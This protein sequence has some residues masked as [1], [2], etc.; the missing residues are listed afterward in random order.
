[1]ASLEHYFLDLYSLEQY[2]RRFFHIIINK[3]LTILFMKLKKS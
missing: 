2:S 1:M 3:Y